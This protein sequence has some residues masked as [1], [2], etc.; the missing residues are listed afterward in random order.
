MSLEVLVMTF[1]SCDQ[2]LEKNGIYYPLAFRCQ[3]SLWYYSRQ[4]W[5][6]QRGWWDR[7]S[8]PNLVWKLGCFLRCSLVEGRIEGSSPAGSVCTHGLF[9]LR[10]HVGLGHKDWVFWWAF[11][12]VVLSTWAYPFAFSLWAL[13]NGQSYHILPWIFIPHGL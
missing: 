12:L 7:W 2:N 9:W 6:W 1:L 13:Q 4:N 11:D 3:P 5:Q 10:F 8:T